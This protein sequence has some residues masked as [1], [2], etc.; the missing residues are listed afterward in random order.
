MGGG[1]I[2]NLLESLNFIHG[3]GDGLDLPWKNIFIYIYVVKLAKIVLRIPPPTYIYGKYRLPPHPHL[4]KFR[5]WHEFF[6]L[7]CFTAKI[8]WLFIN[9]TSVVSSSLLINFDLSKPTIRLWKPSILIYWF[10]IDVYLRFALA[11]FFKAWKKKS[12][13]TINHWPKQKKRSP[14]PSI[15]P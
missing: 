10:G 5:I 13:K 14:K 6:W 8:I 1:G 12:A 2:I 7:T 9:I 15:P 3:G 4:K 11:A